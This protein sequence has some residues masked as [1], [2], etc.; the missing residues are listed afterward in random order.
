MLIEMTIKGLIVDPVT[1][2]PIIILKDLEEKHILPIWV[3]VFEANAIAL[4]VENVSTPRPMTHDLL[5]DVIADLDGQV[6]RAVVTELKG[7]TFY[8][9]IHVTVRGEHLAIDARPSDAIALALRTRAPI[10]VEDAV[11]ERAKTSDLAADRTDTDRLKSW[12]EHL[13]PDQLGKYKM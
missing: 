6:D 5:R 7:N 13:D 10:L 1:N 3:G 2:T 8:A 12:L 4:Q 11:I 9:M